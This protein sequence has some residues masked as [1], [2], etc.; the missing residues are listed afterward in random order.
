M[1]SYIVHR[2]PPSCSGN[3]QSKVFSWICNSAKIIEV[4]VG[5]ASY[6]NVCQSRS[7][8]GRSR[9]GGGGRTSRRRRVAGGG[10]AST[11]ASWRARAA[12]C[13][14]RAARCP[15]PPAPPSATASTRPRYHH[16]VHTLSSATIPTLFAVKSQYKS[17]TI[18]IAGRRFTMTLKFSIPPGSSYRQ[19]QYKLLT[20]LELGLTTVFCKLQYYSHIIKTAKKK[21]SL[22]NALNNYK[23][24]KETCV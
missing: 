20:L 11:A 2:A 17:Q 13:G 19:K 1:V 4:I 10:R 3:S 9:S 5:F 24:L 15:T 16:V 6:C 21:L 12:C 22:R 8:G 18:Q 14:P 7:T 23:S